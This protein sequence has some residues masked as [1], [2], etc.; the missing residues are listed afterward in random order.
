MITAFGGQI[1]NRRRRLPMRHKI[2]YN[3][4]TLTIRQSNMLNHLTFILKYAALGLLIG[5]LYLLATGQ[6]SWSDEKSIQPPQLVFSYAPAID[7]ISRSVVSIY[8]QSN[9]R[10]SSRSGVS[11]RVPYLTKNYLGS[12]VVVS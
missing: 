6:L 1:E 11:P 3:G 8:I 10:V 2:H 12:G 5:L 7:K 4:P 9:E